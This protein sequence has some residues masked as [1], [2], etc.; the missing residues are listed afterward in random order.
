M[1][2]YVYVY[3]INIIYIY[4]IQ[5]YGAQ[6]LTYEGYHPVCTV[7]FTSPAQI[8]LK[9][10]L[11]MQPSGPQPHQPLQPAT[12]PHR[13]LRRPAASRACAGRS[14]ASGTRD[15]RSPVAVGSG[16]RSKT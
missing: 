2:M 15:R 7:F 11:N 3:I 12:A 8:P 4:I 13:P 5:S 9:Y 14:A 1:Y 6:I 10:P 16:S